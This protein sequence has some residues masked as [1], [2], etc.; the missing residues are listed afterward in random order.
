MAPLRQLPTQ[1]AAAIAAGA[2]LLGLCSYTVL[3]LERVF[4]TVSRFSQG[5]T[6]LP[7]L[8]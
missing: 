2:T 8:Q 3:T 1:P 5:A 6:R 4:A 7:N